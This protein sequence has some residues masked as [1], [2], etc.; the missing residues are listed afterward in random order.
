[1]R[2]SRKGEYALRAMIR[3][4]LNYGKSPLRIRD[5]SEREKIPGKFLEQIL[6]ELKKAGLLQSRRGAGGG[7]SLIKPPKEVTLA[8]VIRIIDGPLAPLGCVSRWAYISCPEEDTCGLYRVMLDVRNA[9]AK[10]LEA[11]T[12]ADACRRTKGIEK[13]A[14]KRARAR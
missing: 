3:L 14:K 9:I 10:I 8:Q 1:M 11:V 12:F 4:S 13:K 2:L 5:I 7:Y 6:L